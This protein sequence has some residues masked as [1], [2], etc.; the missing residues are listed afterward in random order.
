MDLCPPSYACSG[1]LTHVSHAS[2]FLG[3]L[4]EGFHGFAVTVRENG[5]R[6]QVTKQRGRENLTCAVP[7][8]AAV[9]SDGL[10]YTGNDATIEGRRILIFSKSGMGVGSLGGMTTKIE[11]LSILAPTNEKRRLGT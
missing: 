4:G 9:P 1:D 10:G 7:L 5:W 6:H 11:I 8:C 3:S 2:T